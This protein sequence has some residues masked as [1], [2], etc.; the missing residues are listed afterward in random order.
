[1][2]SKIST[3]V[4][5]VC[6]AASVFAQTNAIIAYQNGEVKIA[7]ESI[8][9]YFLKEK[10]ATEAKAW[11]YRGAIY[12]AIAFSPDATIKSL[13]TNAIFKCVESYNKAIALDKKD[14]DWQKQSQNRLEGVWGSTFNS[15]IEAYK[16]KDYKKSFQYFDLAKLCKPQDTLSYV[17]GGSIAIEAKDYDYAAASYKALTQ[18]PSVKAGY[19]QNWLYS[20]SEAKKDGEEIL[21]VIQLARKQFPQDVN[22]MK[23]E[24]N[25]Y[26]VL[27]RE[28]EAIVKLEEAVEK[29]KDNSHLYYYNLC[30]IS[31]Q[32]AD[33]ESDATKKKAFVDKSF[34][35]L[36]KSLAK[37]STFE[38][39][40]YMMGFLI[41]EE[42]DVLNKKINNMTGK[43]YATIGKKEEAKRDELYKKSLPYL[44]KAL[45]GNPSDDKLKI[46]ICSLY[47]KFKMQDKSSKLGC[48]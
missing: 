38:G 25:Q 31:K 5:I 27:N 9:K 1:M 47:S 33:K 37:D 3:V 18:M 46:Q 15:A 22:F 26:I 24:V 10:S 40:N 43:E 48:P 4:A 19:F 45:L 34:D 13:D 42:G 16:E 23:L 36:K 2:K 17:Y 6:A 44:E 39:S 8:D 20:V 29:D 7:K 41:M 14:G 11:F 28:K 21:A 35:Y 30:I 12:E 32:M